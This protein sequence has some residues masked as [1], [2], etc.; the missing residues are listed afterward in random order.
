MM[1]PALVVS[2]SAT[3]FQALALREKLLDNLKLLSGFKF[4]AVELH[5]RNPQEIDVKATVAAMKRFNMECPTIGTGQ[6]FFDEGLCL[7]SKDK[8]VRMKARKRMEAQLEF[9]ARFNCYI[10]IGLIRG[11]PKKQDQETALNMLADELGV[12]CE[13]ASRV[14]AAGLILE[15]LNRYET[16]IINTIAEAEALIAKVDADNLGILADSFHMNIEERDI[17]E[18]IKN[19]AGLIMHVH[20]ADSNRWP[21]GSGHFDFDELFKALKKIGYQSFVSGEYMPMPNP[22][23][24]VKLF[25]KFLKQRRLLP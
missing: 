12:L 1:K 16:T 4:K 25:A 13:Y 21:P 22:T 9:A 5:V 10:T 3:G 23:D 17:T 15:P 2:L 18:S 7:T 8:S 19:A 11:V 20:L 24:S 14:G 6:A